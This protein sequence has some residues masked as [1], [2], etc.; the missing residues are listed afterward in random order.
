MNRCG[1]A[2]AQS[3]EFYLDVLWVR[4]TGQRRPNREAY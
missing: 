2:A 4:S 3:A 1:V